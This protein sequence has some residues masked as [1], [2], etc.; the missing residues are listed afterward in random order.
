MSPSEVFPPADLSRSIDHIART[1]R[2]VIPTHIERLQVSEWAEKNRTLTQGFAPGP[3][4][5]SVTPYFREILDCLSVSSPVREVAVMKGSRVGATVALGENFLGYIIAAAPAPTGYITGSADMAGAQMELRVDEM[6]NSAGIGSLIGVRE[7]RKN[8]RVTGDTQ[9]LKRFPGG[10]LLAGG[11][12]ASFFKRA[13]GFLYLY[14]DEI[15]SF[16]DTLGAEGDPIFLYRQRVSE[17]PDDH[18]ILW[19]SSPQLA[20][21]SKIMRLYEEG[22]Q[23]KYFVP[24]R[25]CGH[26]QFLRRFRRGSKG[27]L[28][29]EADDDDR[30]QAEYSEEGRLIR[31][32]VRYECE[33][34]GGK[35]ENKDKSWF[36]PRGEWRPTK[37]T[38]R[39]GLRSYH[40]PGLYSPAGAK[41]WEDQII[42]YLQIKHEQFPALKH[43]VWINTT[44]GEPFIEKGAAPRLEA[45]ITRE[46]N[47]PRGSLPPDARPLIITIGADIQKNRIEAE[48][49]AWGRDAVSWSIDYYVFRGETAD[50]GSDCWEKLREV[51]DT[52]FG[53]GLKAAFMAVD[54]G[55]LS[56]AVYAFAD[57]FQAGVFPVMGSGRDSAAGKWYTRLSPVQAHR[58]PRVDINTQL[59]KDELYRNFNRSIPESGQVPPGYCFFPADYDRQHFNQLIAEQKV[60]KVSADGSVKYQYQSNFRRNEQLDCRVYALAVLYAYRDEIERQSRAEGKL[61]EDEGLTWGCFWGMMEKMRVKK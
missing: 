44:L 30:L 7:K 43:Q 29:W 31:S 50:P 16:P 57:S 45:L 10:H 14:V 56:D 60:A 2:Q 18:K 52:P 37:V 53:G 6:I 39:P 34:C 42:E 3:F 19:T 12:K 46:R 28:K 11:P 17:Y 22:D 54:A 55:Y 48:V 61:A 13:F 5:L 38:R 21:N 15:D 35:W 59:L 1:A 24:C 33:Q 25:H 41:T 32:T 20:E 49:V 36:L 40:L 27:G 4:S 9:T 23:R 58:Q 8:Q 51:F 47:Y 26:M